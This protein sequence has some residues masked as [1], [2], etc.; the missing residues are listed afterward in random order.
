LHRCH[1]QRHNNTPQ[2]DL[3]SPTTR[4]PAARNKRAQTRRS[5]YHHGSQPYISHLQRRGLLRRS[6]AGVAHAAHEPC[7][8][9]KETLSG[10]VIQR[11]YREEEKLVWAVANLCRRWLQ[12]VCL[13]EI[14]WRSGDASSVRCKPSV[15]TPSSPRPPPSPPSSSAPPQTCPRPPPSQPVTGPSSPRVSGRR[16]R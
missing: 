7:L 3:A 8:S 13:C 15:T 6:L 1:G 11:A 2:Q 14:M 10:L 4:G 12:P 16:R 5:S 9:E